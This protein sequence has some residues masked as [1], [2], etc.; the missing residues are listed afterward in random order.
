M[1]LIL[2]ADDFGKTKS[3]NQ[4]V[5]ELAK[6][7][8]L[9]STTVLINA[10]Y[11]NEAKQLID[12]SNF[13]I[14]LHFNLTEGTPENNPAVIPTLVNDSG[15]FHAHSTLIKKLR[16]GKISRFEIIIELKAQ[17]NKLEN[18]LGKRP[19][20]ID[21]HQ[22]IHKQWGVAM[23]LIEFGKKNPDLGL[24]SSRRY[25]I[26][27]GAINR[28]PTGMGLNRKIKFISTNFYLS[29][30]NQK[31]EKNFVLPKGELHYTSLK[32]ID[33]LNWLIE[34]Q[35]IP[36]AESV[37][38]VPCH[39]ASSIE[40]LQD[41][42]LTEKRLL[43]YRIMRSEEFKESIAKITLTNFYNLGKQ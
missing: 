8:T 25:I 17:F 37:F 13:S 24:R 3:I 9:T 14:G 4:A 43:E 15:H 28:T 19:S 11:A 22:N 23:A 34:T 10:P 26:N 18:I 1:R 33:F 31:L 6:L 41:T 2:N 12:F 5:F 7:G 42:K 20:H 32:K 30:L 35:S 29:I 39:P 36:V 21:S 16:S 40:E 38:E 27:D